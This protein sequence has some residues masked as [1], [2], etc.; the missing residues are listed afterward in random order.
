LGYKGREEDDF[1]DVQKYVY[2]VKKEGI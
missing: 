2:G 1:K